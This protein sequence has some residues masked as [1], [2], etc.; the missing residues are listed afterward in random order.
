MILSGI[1]TARSRNLVKFTIEVISELEYDVDLSLTEW[2]L[3]RISDP[4]LLD[5]GP[6]LGGV[7]SSPE[8]S[9]GKCLAGDLTERKRER[10][11]TPWRMYTVVTDLGGAATVKPYLTGHLTFGGK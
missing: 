5:S 8:S 4:N 7:L 3:A 10:G 2:D 6:S 11:L 9:V 1:C